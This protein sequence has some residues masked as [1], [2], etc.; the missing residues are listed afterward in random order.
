MNYTIQLIEKLSTTF[1]QDN[2]LIYAIQI[3]ENADGSQ[4]ITY[5]VRSG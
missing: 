4:S 5:D 3:V 2:N 1:G